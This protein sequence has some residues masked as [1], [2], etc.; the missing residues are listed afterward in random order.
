MRRL[1]VALFAA[2]LSWLAGCDQLGIESASQVTARREAEGKAVGGG[3]RQAAR[4]IEACYEHNGRADKAAVFAGWREMNDYMRENQL[5]AMPAP[6]PA[7]PSAHP[8]NGPEAAD[9]SGAVPGTHE[10]DKDAQPEGAATNGKA[11]R[12]GRSERTGSGGKAGERA[13][14][15]TADPD[16]AD[17]AGT[18]D[19]GRGRGDGDGG[20]ERAR[21]RRR[22]AAKLASADGDPRKD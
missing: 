15:A 9:R 12:S 4:S 14:V 21:G 3:C 1:A 20:G 7:A 11:D 13:G 6:E 18:A 2:T 17:T 10:A 5:E 16:A 8:G 19:A 22:L